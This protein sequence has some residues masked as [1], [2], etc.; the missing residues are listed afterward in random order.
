MYQKWHFCL[1][2]LAL[3]IA[4][5]SIK[6][7]PDIG[8]RNKQYRKNEIQV[9]NTTFRLTQG[10]VEI[11][12]EQPTDITIYTMQ[13]IQKVARRIPAGTASI[14]LEPGLYILQ[15]N[16]KGYKIVIR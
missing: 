4:Q 15:L 10:A 7:P 14:A 13:G 5:Y 1:S 11:S 16:G 12:T 6:E 2:K 8:K 3:L 9:A